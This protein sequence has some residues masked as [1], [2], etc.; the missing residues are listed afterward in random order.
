MIMTNTGIVI[1]ICVKD[2][3]VSSRDTL[4]VKV[5]RLDEE[6]I[7][8]KMVAISESSESNQKNDEDVQVEENDQD[9]SLVDQLLDRAE[10]DD[11]LDRI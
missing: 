3:S 9:Q 7:V 10:N 4:G 11:D 6:A 8:E 1:R 5:I 2:I